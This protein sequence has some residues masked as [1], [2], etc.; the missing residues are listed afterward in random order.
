MKCPDIIHDL[1]IQAIK[2]LREKEDG[3]PPDRYATVV[4]SE[5]EDILKV[6]AALRACALYVGWLN[7]QDHM[8]GYAG[9]EGAKTALLA[10]RKNPQ[11][12]T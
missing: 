5:P 2:A 6:V 1:E 3:Q 9:R 11:R 10:L 7:P 12:I 4:Y 8:T